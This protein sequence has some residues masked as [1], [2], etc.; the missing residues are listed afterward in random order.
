MYELSKYCISDTVYANL[1]FPFN[2][3]KMCVDQNKTQIAVSDQGLHYLPVIQQFKTDRQ[4][5]EC[6]FFSFVLF[7]V[8]FFFKIFGQVW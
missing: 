6:F 3:I 7:F 4:V 8:F 2:F 5:E 1:A